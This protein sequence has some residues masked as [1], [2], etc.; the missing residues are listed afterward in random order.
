VYP[1][2]KP[3]Y[4]WQ[5]VSR[6]PFQIPSGYRPGKF[7]VLPPPLF[8]RAARWR[9][10]ENVSKRVN[11]RRSSAP[12]LLS[13]NSRLQI[14]VTCFTE[15]TA[16]CQLESWFTVPEQTAC[17]HPLRPSGTADLSLAAS[18]FFVATF[19]SPDTLSAA[20]DAALGHLRSQ[21]PRARL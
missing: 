8:S 5:L 13:V 21:E 18:R 20:A 3:F 12:P 10:P 9:H 1:P 15:Q 2:G 6:P 19:V 17:R 7:H 14:G 16:F 4:G 11:P